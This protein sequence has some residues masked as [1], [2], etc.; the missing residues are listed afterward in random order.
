MFVQ[1]RDADDNEVG[2]QVSLDTYSNKADL[3]QLL[4]EILQDAGIEQEE[5]H[6]NQIYQF[7]L[8]DHEVR[9]SI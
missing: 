3:N 2:E 6:Y 4:V 1:F 9:Q 7:F 5:K 8:G